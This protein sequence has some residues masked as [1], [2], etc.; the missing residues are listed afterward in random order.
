MANIYP[1]FSRFE[2]R[3]KKE[4]QLYQQGFTLWFTGLSGSGKSIVAAELERLMTENGHFVTVLDGD[5]LRFGINADLGFSEADRMEN[6][7]RTAEIC[8]LMNNCAIIVI[9]TLVSPTEKMRALA[10]SIIGRD[11]FQTVHISTPL[12]ECERRDVKGLYA[13]A[14]RGEIADFTGVSAPFEP[15]QDTQIEV[16]TTALSGKRSAEIIFKK[17]Q[18]IYGL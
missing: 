4:R 8:R 6:V 1:N 16:D 7:R 14:R 2:S 10:R 3:E 15:P 13:R 5:N 11:S 12:S 9:A 18:Q 17:V